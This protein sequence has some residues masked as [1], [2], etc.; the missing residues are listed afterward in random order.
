MK[1]P[2]RVQK[3]SLVTAYLS[4]LS[5]L[6]CLGAV[7]YFTWQQGSQSPTVAAFAAAVVFFVTAGVV[8]HVMGKA[9]IPSFKLK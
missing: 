5:G 8:L 2:N 1:R 6:G 9:D 4:Y 7:G 3:V